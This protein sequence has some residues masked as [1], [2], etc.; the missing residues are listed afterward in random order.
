MA[1]SRY[2]K[3]IRNA[4]ERTLQISKEARSARCLEI[5]TKLGQKN[6]LY[7]EEKGVLYGSEIAD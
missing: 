6:E 3:W 1:T 5:A 4:D 2:N 7:E